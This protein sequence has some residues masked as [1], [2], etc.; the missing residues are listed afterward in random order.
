M[1]RVELARLKGPARDLALDDLR[2]TREMGDLSEN[3][4]Y[5]EAKGRVLRINTR[6]LEVEDTLKHAVVITPGADSRGRV[7]VG[8]TVTVE[9]RGKTKTYEITGAAETDPARGRISHLSPLGAALIG[10]NA[11]ENTTLEIG[12]KKTEIKV[13]SVQ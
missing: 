8:S 1:L 2:R 7:K 13:I 10:R 5:T 3:A 6:I 9:M 4:A 11:G 12:G